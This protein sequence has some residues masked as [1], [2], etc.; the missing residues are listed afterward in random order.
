[1]EW[2]PVRSPAGT[3][4]GTLD[5]PMMALSAKTPTSVSAMLMV[6]FLTGLLHPTR[7]P[8]TG[9]P[10]LVAFPTHRQGLYTNDHLNKP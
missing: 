9:V 3:G 5:G 4:I 6:T 1:M 7:T 10:V 8:H 2:S